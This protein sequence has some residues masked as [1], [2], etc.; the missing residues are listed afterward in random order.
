MTTGAGTNYVA[1]KTQGELRNP[2]CIFCD[3]CFFRLLHDIWGAMFASYSISSLF[4]F[5]LAGQGGGEFTLR[6]YGY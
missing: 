3:S 6:N 4:T 5:L 2:D 1:K